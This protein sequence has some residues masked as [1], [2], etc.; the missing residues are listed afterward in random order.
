M[1]SKTVKTL[2][3]LG[4]AYV[5]YKL[6]KGENPLSLKGLADDLFDSLPTDI[7][8]PVIQYP[9]GYGQYGTY[10]PYSSYYGSPYGGTPYSPYNYGSS[11]G[12]YNP[13]SYGYNPYSY[14]G[15]GYYNGIPPA[16]GFEFNPYGGQS[17]GGVYIPKVVTA[18]GGIQ[19]MW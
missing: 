19:G 14:G 6:Y 18:S 1:K 17:Y 4:A 9:P 8:P 16:P 10:S 13:Y 15:A 3:Y 5:A 12:A 2:A 7:N 11:Y